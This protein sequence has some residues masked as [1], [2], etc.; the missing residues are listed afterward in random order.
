MQR[1]I[2]IKEWESEPDYMDGVFFG[3][4]CFVKR[5]EDFKNLNGYVGVS[6]GHKFFETDYRDLD[7]EVHGNL[8]FGS[9]GTH[10]RFGY[11]WWFGFD[12]GHAF[13]HAPGREEMLK[14]AG[15]PVSIIHSLM[16]NQVYR[17]M[18]YVQDE[19]IQLAYQLS[20][21]TLEYKTEPFIEQTKLLELDHG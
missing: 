18:K 3:L 13:D 20:D 6:K 21:H 12:C 15:M 5:H 14:N 9:G 8:T 1:E 11:H 16:S 2:M 4:P 19:C 10:Q 7:V 17:N